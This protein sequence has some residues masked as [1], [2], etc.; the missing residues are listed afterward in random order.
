MSLRQKIII[1]FG[2]FAVVPLLVLASVSSWQARNLVSSLANDQAAATALSVAADLAV[3]RSII[4]SN[5]KVLARETH[6]SLPI[7]T[8]NGTAPGFSVDSPLASAAFVGFRGSDGNLDPVLGS[9]PEVQSRCVDGIETHLVSFSEPVRTDPDFVVEAGFW[10]SDLVLSLHPGPEMPPIQVMDRDGSDLLGPGCES[11]LSPARSLGSPESEV[12]LPLPSER[13]PWDESTKE[14]DWERSTATVEGLG[15]SVTAYTSTTEAMGPLRQITVVYWAF[16]LILS[17]STALVFSLMLGRFTRSLTHLSRA[18]EEIGLGELDPWLPLANSGEVGQLTLAFS[19]M[20]GRI[21]EMMMQVGQSGRLAVIGQMSAY[22]AHEIRNPLSSIKMNLQ[23]LLRWTR[24]GQL[25][26]YCRE[27]LEISLKEVERLNNSV[28]GV[29]QLSG[30]GEGPKEIVELHEV[31]DEATE[32]LSS[33]FRRQGVDLTLDLDA[34]AD[35]ILARPGQLKSVTLNLIMNALEAQPGGGHLAIET[36]LVSSPDFAGPAIAIHFRDQGPGVPPHVR[37]RIF[38]PFF[39]TK[40]GGSGIGLA[41]A[42]QAV[43][44]SGGQLLL[45]PSLP[46][47]AGAEFVVVLPLASTDSTFSYPC[48]AGS[49]YSTAH[50]RSIPVSYDPGVDTAKPMGDASPDFH[51]SG[52]REPVTSPTAVNPEDIL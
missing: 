37:D 13:P 14:G 48:S 40:N 34:D 2:L 33:R 30:A 38:E 46:P 18:A 47:Q 4:Q 24:S 20:L 17:F 5:L 28:S 43:E 51:V 27:P 31:L 26:E 44:D 23:R 36:A 45:M 6:S 16:V 1:L 11:D 15:W 25:P 32:L 9:V 10:V 41:M 42:K 29:L 3:Q 21:R 35:L 52:G 50:P 12:G 7:N 22:L 39:T 8:S 19:R 49:R